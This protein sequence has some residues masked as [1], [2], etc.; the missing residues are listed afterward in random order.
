MLYLTLAKSD[1]NIR[2]AETASNSVNDTPDSLVWTDFYEL[3]D[4]DILEA[5]KNCYEEEAKSIT[6]YKHYEI[7]DKTVIEKV[8]KLINIKQE[9]I[10]QYPSGTTSWSFIEKE[11]SRAIRN[12]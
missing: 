4:P 6:T 7:T 3:A 1:T 5:I 12:V 8:M 10:S 11:I 9:I 2:F